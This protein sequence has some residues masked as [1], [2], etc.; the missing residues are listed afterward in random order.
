MINN[1]EGVRRHQKAFLEKLKAKKEPY[2]IAVHGINI[3]IFPGVFPPAT[4]T[5][6]LAQHIHVRQSERILDLTAG[7]GIFAVLAGL[8]GATGIAA[9]INQ[10]AVKNAKYNF[11]QYHLSIGAVKSNLFENIPQEQ[12]DW[13][14]VN[15]P[16]IE[17]EV[18]DPLEY[19]FY[20]ARQFLTN[21][22]SQAPNYLKPTGKILITIAEWGE[23][24]FFETLLKDNQYRYKIIDKKNSN[25]NQRTYRLYELTRENRHK[26]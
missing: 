14:F 3:T 12:F 20:G 6:L 10:G 15:G 21:F 13:I 9:D 17:G 22:L 19:A 1:Q 26:V 24:E 25:D 5:E 8:Q 4:D 18:I 23:L 16:Y 2:T 7:S 11:T